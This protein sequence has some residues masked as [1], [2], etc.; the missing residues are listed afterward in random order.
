MLSFVCN[1]LALRGGA[2]TLLLPLLELSVLWSALI[3]IVW[4]GERPSRRTIAGATLIVAGSVVL[5]MPSL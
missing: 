5:S 3:A 4:F 2:L 1:A